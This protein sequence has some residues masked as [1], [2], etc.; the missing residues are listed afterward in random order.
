MRMNIIVTGASS[1]I[2]YETVKVFSKDSAHNIIAIARSADKLNSL[3]SDCLSQNQDTQ[4]HPFPFDLSETGFINSLL[5]F[6][7]AKFKSLDILINNAGL[8]LNKHFEKISD[9]EMR[10]V[11][12]T[13]FFSPFSIIKALLPLLA[14]NRGD[15][16]MAK[17]SHII[18]I[19]SMGGYQG[20]NKFPGLSIYS[21]SKAALAN[22]SE[23]LAVELQEKN[24]AVNCL[25]LGAVQTEMLE[26]AFPDFQA[27]LS[28]MEM[29]EFIVKFS[30]NGHQYFNG[31]VIPVSLAT[32]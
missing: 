9:N 13:N 2:G 5:P 17:R 7:K 23:C 27:P 24:I 18:N 8:L 11:F 3:R 4:V 31:K 28:A 19:G 16:Q 29:A 14:K 22:L 20:S 32:I 12:E 6:V 1:G 26:I 15:E 21:S 25:A 30:I 10:K